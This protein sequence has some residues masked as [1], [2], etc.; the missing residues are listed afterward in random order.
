MSAH[1]FI[2]GCAGPAL[3]DDERAF[4]RDADPWGLILFRRNVT[5]R[6]QLRALTDS[7]RETVGRDD[8]PVLVDQEGGRVQRLTAPV[9]RRYPAAAF[10][11]RM[12]WE[13]PFY[14]RELV[15]LSAQLMGRDLREVGITVDCAPVADVPAPGSHEIVGDRA[16]APDPARAAVLARAAAEGLLAAGVLPVV[17]HMPG[18]GRALADSHHE[19]PVVTATREEL[20]ASDFVTFR[21]LADMPLA[22]SAHVV[23]ADIDPDNPATTSKRVVKKIMRGALNFDG[24]ITS[25][26]LS[27]KALAGDMRE[28]AEAAFKAGL[29]MA[30]HCNGDLAEMQAVAQAAPKLDGKAKRR[31]KAALRRLAHA[32]EPFDPVDAARRLDQALAPQV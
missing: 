13:D 27:M 26:D 7:F 6:E 16:Y 24:L 4:I 10:F 2:C 8:A 22:M 14:V 17:K 5:D 18:H 15:R 1:A 21:A 28:R 9:W 30:L 32:P 31:A 12:G 23:Y 3:T 29:D 20:E 19:L 25:D 11:E